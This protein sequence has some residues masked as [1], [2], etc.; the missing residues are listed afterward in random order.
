MKLQFIYIWIKTCF[1]THLPLLRWFVYCNVKCKRVNDLGWLL[2]GKFVINTNI[3]IYFQQPQY[4]QPSDLPFYEENRKKLVVLVVIE[5]LRYFAITSPTL[6]THSAHP[7]CLT[8]LTHP[9]TYLLAYMFALLIKAINLLISFIPLTHFPTHSPNLSSPIHSTYSPPIPHP[10]SFTSPIYLPINPTCLP[11][12]SP[13][14]FMSP[15]Y[16][17]DPL[18]RFT[19][20]FQFTDSQHQYIRRVVFLLGLKLWS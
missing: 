15:I 14:L 11:T 20:L 19:R 7:I 13:H 1:L 4:H 5:L 3:V 12:L 9:F 10:H 8:Y 17:T 16:L 2:P 18:N 6:L